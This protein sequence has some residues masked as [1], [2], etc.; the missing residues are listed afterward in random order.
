MN[1]WACRR[2]GN[3]GVSG[4]IK[5]TKDEVLAWMK[6]HF[7]VLCPCDMEHRVIPTGRVLSFSVPVKVKGTMI[8]VSLA[9]F[10]V[11]EFC[12]PISAGRGEGNRC[13]ACGADSLCGT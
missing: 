2:Q 4:A 1:K 5:G 9:S 6:S 7:A 8:K 13:H 10:C 3:L 11:M 12:A